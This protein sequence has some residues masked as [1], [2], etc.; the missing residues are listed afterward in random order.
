MLLVASAPAQRVES[1]FTALTGRS[2]TA[3]ARVGPVRLRAAD[4]ALH[5]LSRLLDAPL[6][7]RLL[8]NGP[9]GPAVLDL[10][11][12]RVIPARAALDVPA[13][14]LRGQVVVTSG[15][16]P[17]LAVPLGGG[18]PTPLGP[19]GAVVAAGPG[20]DQVWVSADGSADAALLDTAGRVLRRVRMPGRLQGAVRGN[21]VV[22]GG[23]RF[24]VW[25]PTRGRTVRRLPPCGTVLTAGGAEVVL[26]DCRADSG[27]VGLLHVVDV[28]SGRDRVLRL[29]AGEYRVTAASLAPDGSQLSIVARAGTGVGRLLVGD[30]PAGRLTP[31]ETPGAVSVVDSIVWT[32]DSRRLFLTAGESFEAPA[33]SLWTYRLGDPAATAIRYLRDGPVTPIVVLPTR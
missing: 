22:A 20:A 26:T 21:L 17:V 6:P 18:A 28:D 7:V 10:A 11:A 9:G 25:D 1:D 23:G 27:P 2:P 16:L 13:G 31:V 4:A 29:P 8:V 32:A 19:A 14:L 5:R 12:N 24:S 33:A 30:I 3:S 15:G